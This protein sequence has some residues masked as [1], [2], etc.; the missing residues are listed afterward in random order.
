[1]LLW[2]AIGPPTVNVLHQSVALWSSFFC[3]WSCRKWQ[4][5]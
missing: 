3:S 2:H 4:L 1:M 5:N